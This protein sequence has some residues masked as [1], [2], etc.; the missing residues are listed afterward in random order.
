MQTDYTLPL[1]VTR[2]G[3]LPVLPV[4]PPCLGKGPS[5][6]ANHVRICTATNHATVESPP[7][8][9]RDWLLSSLWCR[10][11]IWKKIYALSFFF[12]F[13]LSHFPPFLSFLPAFNYHPSLNPPSSNIK[14]YFKRVL[15]HQLQLSKGSF[16]KKIAISVSPAAKSHHE[17]CFW[18]N[19]QKYLIKIVG[20]SWSCFFT[21]SPSCWFQLMDRMQHLTRL[22]SLVTTSFVF[23]LSLL[24]LAKAIRSRGW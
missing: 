24:L 1:S 23:F 7:E 5:W 6:L 22:V 2:S 14:G 9:P 10:A 17:S 3:G 11:G 19:W 15:A 8:N 13:H 20:F 16:G 12:S 18:L 4:A 21:P